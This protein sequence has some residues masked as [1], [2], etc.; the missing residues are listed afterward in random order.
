MFPFIVERLFSTFLHLNKE[1]KVYSNPYDY[2]VYQVSEFENILEILNHLKRQFIETK[3]IDTYKRWHS[4]RERILTD[5]PRIF[6]L[7]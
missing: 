5:H 3:D 1:Y 2:S 6:H 7:D 4:L